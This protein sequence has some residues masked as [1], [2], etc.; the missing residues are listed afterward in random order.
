M[1]IQADYGLE[2]DTSLLVLR[3][4]TGEGLGVGKDF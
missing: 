1:Q 3:H 2:T 4:R